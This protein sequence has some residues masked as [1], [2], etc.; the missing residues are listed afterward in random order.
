MLQAMA[1]GCCPISARFGGQSEYYDMGVGRI[2][3][4]KQVAGFE[5][6]AGLGS[7]AEL[8]EESMIREM[9]WV[10][11]NRKEAK[12]LGLLAAE[13]AKYFTWQNTCD[14]FMKILVE[15]GVVEQ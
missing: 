9:R 7:W 8:S 2:I 6:Y 5:D 1:V 11:E 12:K 3:E 4:F 15:F 10:Y 14:E 13:R